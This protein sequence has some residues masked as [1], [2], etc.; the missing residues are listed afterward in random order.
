MSG[1]SSA[2]DAKRVTHHNGG[3]K[4]GDKY[5]ESLDRLLADIKAEYQEKDKPAEMKTPP[6]LKAEP[7]ALPTYQAPAPQKTKNFSP[8][9]EYSLIAELKT[10]YGERDR[11]EELKRQ[12]QLQEEQR[13]QQQ[14]LEQQRQ[15]LTL[16]AQAWLK[17]LDPLS[18]EGLWFEELTG[19]YPSRLEAAIDYLQALQGK[20]P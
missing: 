13:R 6:A 2:G 5:M 9:S 8:R 14:L 7:H 16:A 4:K 11:A 20:N 17:E 10:E 12:Q 18:D 19:K 15:K 3:V 1:L